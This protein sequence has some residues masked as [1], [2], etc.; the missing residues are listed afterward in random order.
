M[1]DIIP[2]VGRGGNVAGPGAVL[3][4]KCTPRAR[5]ALAARR[6]SVVPPYF[7]PD[8]ASVRYVGEGGVW[9]AREGRG[10]RAKTAAARCSVQLPGLTRHP[11]RVSSVREPTVG[12]RGAGLVNIGR[13]AVLAVLARQ[14]ARIC[15]RLAGKT[16]LPTHRLPYASPV[17]RDLDGIYDGVSCVEIPRDVGLASVPD[18]ASERQSDTSEGV[19]CGVREDIS[20]VLADLGLR[21][22]FSDFGTV[23]TVL[24][25]F[26]RRALHFWMTS[27][28]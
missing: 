27:G 19:L 24:A 17:R 9:C 23:H 13:Q 10:N 2:L 3:A 15:A 14:C 4:G 25:R 12:G 7:I 20:T 1:D 22:V 5:L 8:R 11:P 18:R 16:V 26:W 28:I 21:T 6:T